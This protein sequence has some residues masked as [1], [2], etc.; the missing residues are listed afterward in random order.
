M[1]T[2][3]PQFSFRRLPQV[4]SRRR[5]SATYTYDGLNRRILKT[6]PTETRHFYY[7]RNWQCLLE[8]AENQP[9]IHYAWGLRYIDDLVCRHVGLDR[10]YALPDSNWNV[11]A[12]TSLDATPL[13][14]YTYTAF[15][16]LHIYDGNFIPQSS[17]NYNWTRTFT[18]QILDVETGLMLYRN[19]FYHSNLGRF[20]TRDP[21]GY[22]G[23]DTNLYRYVRNNG[24]RYYDRY[25]C[26][27]VNNSIFNPIT[28]IPNI[29]LPKVPSSP[30]SFSP[31]HE[32][33]ILEN[34]DFTK[35]PFER[36]TVDI[37]DDVVLSL[38]ADLFP[39]EDEN[40][41]G[42]FSVEALEFSLALYCFQMKQFF[43]TGIVAD[44]AQFES[45][46]RQAKINLYQ[47]IF[48]SLPPSDIIAT[49]IDIENEDFVS[50][51]LSV[52]AENSE[53][54]NRID[55]AIDTVKIANLIFKIQTM[56][57]IH[58]EGQE[59]VIND[60]NT[61]CQGVKDISTYVTNPYA[62]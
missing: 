52:L 3:P 14:R 37:S 48:L 1:K 24:L 60:L 6:T 5:V 20:I 36:P 54:V 21:I 35:N 2:L 59:K 45:D 13:E 16:K 29:S 39:M 50:I 11:V 19:R 62:G 22:Y 58:K 28:G 4:H 34:L 15:G 9:S 43:K 27:I 49:A 18:G 32:S 25:G 44:K 10:I 42:S 31:I 47:E 33:E 61:L 7:N 46:L 51:I 55:K 26:A 53:T 40:I 57:R 38:L 23:K 56:E 17:S 30:I 41:C 12:L 8:T